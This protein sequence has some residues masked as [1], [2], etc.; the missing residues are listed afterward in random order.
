MT[1]QKLSDQSNGE[2]T[3]RS[4]IFLKKWEV[5]ILLITWIISVCVTIYLTRQTAQKQLEYTVQPSCSLVFERVWNAKCDSS[6]FLLKNQGPSKLDEVWFK[7]K[8]F[9]V[10]TQGVHECPD[11]PH[12]EYFYFHGSPRSMGSLEPDAEKKIYLSPCWRLAYSLFLTKF[13]GVLVSRFTLNGSSSASPEFRKDYFYVI[14]AVHCNYMTPEE[15]VGGKDLV[16]NVI[17]YAEAGPKSVIYWVGFANDFFKNPPK[18]WYLQN[19][20]SGGVATT[21]F[22]FSPYSYLPS[23]GGSVKFGWECEEDTFPIVSLNGSTESW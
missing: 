3:N 4:G 16:D 11:L 12:F 2:S 14:D 9:L 13:P 18:W 7:E 23:K 20:L 21:F 19:E 6:Y 22:P 8:V 5:V 1:K 10:D 15:H 17:K